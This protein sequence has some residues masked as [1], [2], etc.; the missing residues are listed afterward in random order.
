V[1]KLRPEVVAHHQR[2]RML[3]A[4]VTLVAERGYRSVTVADIV[5]GGKVARARFYENFSSKEDCFTAAYERALDDALERVE[6]AC[7]SAGGSFPDRVAAGLT[8]L[9]AFIASQPNLARACLL[10]GPSVGAALAPQNE[11]ALRG[12]GKLLRGGRGDRPAELPDTTEESVLGGLYWLLYNSLL[13]GQ[14]E[15]IEDLLPQLVEF[16][17][18]PFL[19]SEAAR[20]AAAA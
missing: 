12:F 15:R 7:D 17:L 4:A 13:S 18:T 10:E 11:K 3:D 19:G 16:A 1:H 20:E 5:K 2:E 14:P 8:A 6:K 9:L